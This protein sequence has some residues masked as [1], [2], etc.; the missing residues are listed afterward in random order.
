MSINVVVGI[1]LGIMMF[2][3]AIVIFTSLIHKSENLSGTIDSQTKAKIESS[4]DSGDPIYVPETTIQSA[5][6]SATFWIGIR[7]IG[8]ETERFQVNI[9]P[10]APSDF[11]VQKIGYIKDVYS[12]LAKDNKFV[13]VVVDTKGLTQDITLLVNVTENSTST[14]LPDKQYM[15]PKIVT[16]QN[17]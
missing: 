15:K 13:V 3:A 9:K 5:K 10:L 7:N 6:G 16:I 8:S 4:L 2:I 1:I 12:I 14:G 17:G 11:D